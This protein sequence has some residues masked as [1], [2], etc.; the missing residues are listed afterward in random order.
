MVDVSEP[1]NVAELESFLICINYYRTFVLCMD[2]D[3]NCWEDFHQ[4]KVALHVSMHVQLPALLYDP[5]KDII[6]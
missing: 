6:R 1:R 2:L 5:Q 4:A 3:K